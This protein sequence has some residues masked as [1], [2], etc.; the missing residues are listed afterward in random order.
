MAIKECCQ[1]KDNLYLDED[2]TKGCMEGEVCYR[3][4]VCNCRHFQVTL[5]PGHIGL[6]GAD[7]GR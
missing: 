3:C 1:K 7:T 5:D 4:R 6:R 2:E